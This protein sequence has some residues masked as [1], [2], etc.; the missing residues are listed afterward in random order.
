MG[1]ILIDAG[2]FDPT[3]IEGLYR[4]LEGKSRGKYFIATREGMQ[5]LKA[6]LNSPEM[7]LEIEAHRQASRMANGID[8]ETLDSLLSAMRRSRNRANEFGK[9][10]DLDREWLIDT[11]IQQRGVCALTGM[12]LRHL[13]E[14][15]LR[16]NPFAPSIDRIDCTVGYLKPN[17]Q[18]TTVMANIAKSDFS[19]LD[20]QRMCA[21]TA[22]NLRLI[23]PSI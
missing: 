4:G 1:M 18:I 10:F 19:L 6:P 23:G 9:A 5:R 17:C 8:A 22:V 16:R 13:M 15:D 7:K 12:E 21:H 3:G 2:K 11:Y 14:G 20:F